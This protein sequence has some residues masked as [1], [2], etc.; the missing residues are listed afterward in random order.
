MRIGNTSRLH[1]A[2]TS[3]ALRAIG[4]VMNNYWVLPLEQV[5]NNMHVEEYCERKVA[6]S[7]SSVFS[8]SREG[9][10]RS[11]LLYCKVDTKEARISEYLCKRVRRT[12]RLEE[13]GRVGRVEHPE[14]SSSVER[15]ADC[16]QGKA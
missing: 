6:S 11:G 4:A 14:A 15:R 1:L 3:P 16:L 9:A 10:T 13:R 12:K 2:T 8:R 7:R 5:L